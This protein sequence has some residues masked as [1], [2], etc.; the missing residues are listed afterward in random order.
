[1]V[2]VVSLVVLEQDTVPLNLDKSTLFGNQVSS[3]HHYTDNY[4]I[5][6]MYFIFPELSV[7]VS[8]KYKLK[9]TLLQLDLKLEQVPILL[10]LESD[11]FR[12]GLSRQF[13][14]PPVQTRLSKCL[15]KQGADPR[16]R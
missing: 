3:C 16:L 6:G 11:E 2:C 13:T 12:V 4:G 15:T 1:M 8:G 5:P 14:G 7:H 10:H 9:C